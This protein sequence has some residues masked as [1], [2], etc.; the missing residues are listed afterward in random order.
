MKLN[1]IS[2]FSACVIWP[3]ALGTAIYVGWRTT[4]LLVF[5]WMAICGIPSDVFRPRTNI[6]KVL[7]YSLPDACW[8][9]AGTSW[10]LI[11]WRRLHAWVFIFGALAI[12]G[13]FGQAFQIVPGTFEWKDITFCTGGFI[14]ALIGH[15][16]A[17]TLFINNRLTD[18]GCTCRRQCGYGNQ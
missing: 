13:E 7:L 3:I 4:S 18:Y 1:N 5:D 15:K 6:P 14:L 12:G 2:M 10:M 8:V 11:I 9:F 16:Y 17:Q